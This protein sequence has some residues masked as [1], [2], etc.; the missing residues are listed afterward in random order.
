MFNIVIEQ[1]DG[2]L[3]QTRA[4]PFALQ[5]GQLFWGQKFVIS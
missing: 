4:C 3:K 1:V 2:L 5:I